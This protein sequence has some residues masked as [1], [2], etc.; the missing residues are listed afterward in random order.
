MNSRH[1]LA[2]IITK[3]WTENAFPLELP[4][5]F[6]GAELGGLGYEG[7]GCA[8]GS[9]MLVDLVAME[10][11]RVDSSIAIAAESEVS[12]WGIADRWRKSG[13]GLRRRRCR[14]RESSDPQKARHRGDSRPGERG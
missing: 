2:P 9:Q 1:L 12:R 3:Y 7:Y 11:S 14:H 4:P 6:K 5:A 10:T 13:P 8:S